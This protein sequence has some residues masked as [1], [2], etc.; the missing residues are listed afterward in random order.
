MYY[1]I[2]LFFFIII[3]MRCSSALCFYLEFNYCTTN[4]Q[5]K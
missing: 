4:S 1:V 2:D 3:S 5:I